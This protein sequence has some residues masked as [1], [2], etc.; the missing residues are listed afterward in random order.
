[1]TSRGVG[2]RRTGQQK[3]NNICTIVMCDCCIRR[4]MCRLKYNVQF[5]NTQIE[6]DE[7]RF[8]YSHLFSSTSSVTGIL[9]GTY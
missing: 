2:E 8:S 3:N 7:E 6:Y 5:M 4:H 1:M 9:Q